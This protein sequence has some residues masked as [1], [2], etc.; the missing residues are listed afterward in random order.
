LRSSLFD[1]VAFVVCT[2]AW[3]TTWYAITL[4]LGV[5]DPMVSV[6]YRFG[7]AA[8]LLALWALAAK[9]PIALTRRQH[10][11]AFATGVTTF[12]VQYPLVYY[13][14]TSLASAVVAVLFAALS[15]VN[16]IAF[17]LV[18]GQ[19]APALA[20]GAA[21]LGIVGVAILSWGELRAARMDGAAGVGLVFAIAGVLTSALGN[22]GAREAER[23]GA[24]VVALTA[25]A[26][27]YG[28]LALSV[29]AV[30]RGAAWT[31]DPRPTYVMVLL[32]LATFGSV[33]A[34]LLYFALARRRGYASAAYISALTPPVAMIVSAIFEGKRWSALALAGVGV[35]ALGQRLLLR[36]GRETKS[37]DAH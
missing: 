1:V 29:I 13:A 24:G 10:V 6:V 23:R 2:L 12:A 27:A 3:G 15:F 20:W 7:I 19:R 9:R 4:Q 14:E 8:L 22:I 30:V 32:Y 36:A 34:F 5:V 31:F 18:Y 37:A 26:M 17:R 21:C 11:V 35:I 28:T 16:L 25:W 33:V